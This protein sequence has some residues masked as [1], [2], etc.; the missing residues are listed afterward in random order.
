MRNL[1]KC[2]L[3]LNLEVITLG[4]KNMVKPTQTSA[5]KI[6]S[7]SDDINDKCIQL[8]RRYLAGIWSTATGADVRVR[9]VSGGRTN[10]LCLCQLTS[11]AAPIA[12]DACDEPQP[13]EVIV[14]YYGWKYDF[15]IGHPTQPRFNDPI[16]MSLTSHKRLGP[17]V[18][19]LDPEGE[20]LRYYKHRIFAKSDINDEQLMTGLARQLARFHALNAPLGRDRDWIC[21]YFE[22]FLAESGDKVNAMLE[23]VLREYGC[24]LREPTLD[25]KAEIQWLIDCI[26]GQWSDGPL[27]FS[28]NGLKFN[29]IMVTDEEG[30]EGSPQGEKAMMID[31]EF[32]TYGNRG[33]DLGQF[34]MPTVEI[35]V[36]GKIEF[37][38]EP[39]MRQFIK[40]Y[41]QESVQLYGSQWATK[42]YNTADYMLIYRMFTILLF[43]SPDTRR[44]FP[45]RDI[46][47][48]LYNTNVNQFLPLKRYFIEHVHVPSVTMVSHG[49]IRDYP[50][51]SITGCGVAHMGH[52]LEE[53]CFSWHTS[54]GALANVRRGRPAAP[55]EVPWLVYITGT[56]NGVNFSASGT[57]FNERWIITAGQN[58]FCGL[59]CTVAN[60]RIYPSAF[61]SKHLEHTQYYEAKDTHVHPMFET[62]DKANKEYDIGLIELN[63]AMVF[64]QETMTLARPVCL[65]DMNQ[66]N[67][68]GQY[69]L[70]AGYGNVDGLPMVGWTKIKPFK[71]GKGRVI[72]ATRYPSQAGEFKCEGDNGGPLIQYIDNGVA[73]LI[74]IYSENMVYKNGQCMPLK[75]KH[76][77]TFTRVSRQIEWILRVVRRR[78][79][80][81]Q[82][83][84]PFGYVVN[85]RGLLA[86]D[87]S[88]KAAQFTTFLHTSESITSATAG[89]YFEL[90]YMSHSKAINRST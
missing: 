88:T 9:P 3:F 19:G 38:A 12:G 85:S 46:V 6:Y 1:V 58:T 17:H 59:R 62:S 54:N 44:E 74:G 64:D 65:P 10:H 60:L 89:L 52:K 77:L 84:Y 72:V 82:V 71:P 81:D 61:S 35:T 30:V 87:H 55:G 23:A 56:Q 14:K 25:L 68:D 90:S 11:P 47:K 70:F 57:I 39:E 8:C 2:S 67:R 21:N 63:T 73:V 29:N 51:V 15:K 50:G 76:N 36:D 34:F 37:T 22:Q 13:R 32:S 78:L 80:K 86:I 79:G 33:Y 66:I 18:Y 43:L 28:H 69:A 16:V 7:G 20:V 26:R 31:F 42:P 83:G 41:R 40:V 49:T 45:D 75:D 4:A 24:Q 53:G 27:V 48:R 5:T